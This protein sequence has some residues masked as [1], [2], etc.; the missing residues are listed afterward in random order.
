MIYVVHKNSLNKGNKLTIIPVVIE[1]P[2]TSL[3]L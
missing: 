2:E 3:K 1:N